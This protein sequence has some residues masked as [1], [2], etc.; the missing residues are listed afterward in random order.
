MRDFACL[1]DLQSKQRWSEG[2]FSIIYVDISDYELRTVWRKS[3]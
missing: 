3:N 2:A 1:R